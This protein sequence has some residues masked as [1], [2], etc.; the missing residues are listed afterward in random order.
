MIDL[1]SIVP[2]Q[3]VTCGFLQSQTSWIFFPTAIEIAVSRDGRTFEQAERLQFKTAPDLE[4]RVEDYPIQLKSTQARYVRVRASNVGI[5]PKWHVGA[6]GKAWLFAD[7][8]VV[9]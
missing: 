7:E 9:R 3:S 6:G 2:V 8:I 4:P 5:C 1:G